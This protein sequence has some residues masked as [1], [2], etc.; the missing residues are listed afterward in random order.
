MTKVDFWFDPM[1]P[2]AW[3]TSRWMLEVERVRDVEVQWHVM[4]LAVLNEGREM[5]EEY[6][7]FL[8][9]AWKPVRVVVAAQ[10]SRGPGVTLDLYTALGEQIHV[11]GIRDIDEAIAKALAGVGLPAE[12][13]QAA[14]PTPRRGT[15]RIPPPRYGSRGRGRRHPRH[16][17]AWRGR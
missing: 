4:S 6:R 12:L 2:W 3:M 13:A 14:D 1:C 16:P 9:Q 11:E 17:C 7:D 10:Q 15:A 8:V 5:P